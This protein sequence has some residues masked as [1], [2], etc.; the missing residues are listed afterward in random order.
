[1]GFRNTVPCLWEAV[2]NSSAGWACAEATL[3]LACSGISARE[4]GGG[5][6]GLC[7]SLAWLLCDLGLVTNPLWTLEMGCWGPQVG[8]PH[9]V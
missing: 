8:V 3:K 1:M 6:P 7:F 9:S 5:E 2:T 4:V